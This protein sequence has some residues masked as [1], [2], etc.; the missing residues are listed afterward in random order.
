M[1]GLSP[2]FTRGPLTGQVFAQ[3]FGGQ[4]LARGTSGNAN[5]L[6]PAGADE[7]NCAGVA[8]TD[9]LPAGTST[10]VTLA[11]G[12]PDIDLTLPDENVAYARHGIYEIPAV[13]TINYLDKV[14]CAAAGKVT[15]WVKG[16]DAVDLIVGEQVLAGGTTDGNLAWIDLSLS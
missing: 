5:L 1:P 10:S 4:L 12:Y 14:K 11:S 15:K 13:G 6:G 8:T 16:T 3:V 2:K 7:P 9:A